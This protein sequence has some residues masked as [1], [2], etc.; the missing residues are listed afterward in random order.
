[1]SNH[2][3]AWRQAVVLSALMVVL[4]L[5]GNPLATAQPADRPANGDATSSDEAEIRRTVSAYEA[6]FEAHEATALAALFSTDA[7]IVNE[8]GHSIQ[9]REAIEK[10][11]D[12]IFAQHKDAKVKI[13]I[14][15]IKF[16]SSDVAIESGSSQG[17][18]SA[19]PPRP[20]VRYTAVHVKRDGKWLINHVNEAQATTAIQADHHLASLV[21]LLGKWEA[22]LGQGKVYRLNC[23]W[24][25]GQKFLK[26]IFT[27]EENG[28]I[29]TTGTQIIGYDPIVAQ[30]T[31]WTFDSTGGFG[32]EVW[33]DHGSR[34]RIAA[35]S[36]LPDGSTSL[37]TNYLT[38]GGA[39]AFTWQSVERSVNTQLL[40]DTAVVSVK[41]VEK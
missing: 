11:F 12:E 19:G 39:N 2:V 18:S 24:M 30:V 1:M 26:R 41:R 17:Q 8:L 38:P 4:L 15:S 16:L 25:P 14:D 7:Q 22:D 9:G 6:A 31:S 32:H 40:P 29:L 36:V 3:S 35:S 27:V 13:L 37:A 10:E 20:V 33:E 21:F 5:V 28:T 23:D 34:W